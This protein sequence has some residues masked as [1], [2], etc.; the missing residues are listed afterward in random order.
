MER[1]IYFCFKKLLIG[2]IV[3][4]PRCSIKKYKN[5]LF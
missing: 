4:N 1:K 2:K 5:A 3:K